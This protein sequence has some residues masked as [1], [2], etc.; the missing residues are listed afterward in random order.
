[1]RIT[2]TATGRTILHMW[3][4]TAAYEEQKAGLFRSQCTSV[5]VSRLPYGTRDGEAAHRIG[6]RLAFP[7]ATFDAAYLFHVLEHHTPDETERLIAD[8]QRVLKPGGIVRISSPDLERNGRLYLDALERALADPSPPNVLNYRWAVY[9]LFDQMVR[10]HSGGMMLQ[11][12]RDGAFEPGFLRQ[13]FGDALSRDGGFADGGRRRRPRRSLSDLLA[14]PV[15]RL[16]RRLSVHDPRVTGEADM[17][18]YDFIWLQ[19][20]LERAGFAGV[21]RTDFRT[22]AIPGWEHFD[23]DRSTRGDYPIEPSLYIE[24]RKPGRSAGAGR[25]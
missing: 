17:W 5:R 9:N 2:R 18:G 24:C 20:V 16:I 1:M 10:E 22:S 12:L 8:L 4:G 11:A 23:F 6:T 15:R 19:Q 13:T 25:V 21:T 3:R 14:A 7:A